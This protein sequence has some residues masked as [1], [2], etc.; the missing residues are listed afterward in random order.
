M[1]N[2]TKNPLPPFPGPP[3]MAKLL[4]AETEKLLA[5]GIKFNGS[6]QTL[7]WQKERFEQ[8]LNKST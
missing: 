8:A 4:L 1:M 7:L 5:K 2:D 3:E 6:Q